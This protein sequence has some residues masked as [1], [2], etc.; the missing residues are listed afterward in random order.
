M[1][2]AI[3]RS[4]PQSEGKEMS[5]RT[6]NI[7]IMLAVSAVI[8]W[9][10]VGILFLRLNRAQPPQPASAADARHWKQLAGAVYLQLLQQQTPAGQQMQIPA[11]ARIEC[12]D[13]AQHA[14][15]TAPTPCAKVIVY[16]PRDFPIPKAYDDNGGA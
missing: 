1:R 12:A 6:K 8:G 7:L 15:G 5:T 13:L 11:G 14:Y 2:H 3:N 16:P 4:T 9:V 10:L